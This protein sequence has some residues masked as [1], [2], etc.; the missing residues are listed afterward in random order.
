MAN[1]TPS[2]VVKDL[3]I[4]RN[5]NTFKAKW[6]VP[7]AATQS[8]KDNCFS[9]LDIWVKLYYDVKKG[10]GAKP[11]TWSYWNP[12]MSSVEFDYGD[13]FG[14]RSNLAPNGKTAEAVS[15]A[16]QG[17]HQEGSSYYMGPW[18]SEKL[19]YFKPPKAPKL[20]WDF[21]YVHNQLATLTVK[22]DDDGTEHEEWY[23]TCYCVLMT[24]K[25][26][27]EKVVEKWTT[28]RNA[29]ATWTRSFTTKVNELNA[30][31]T[32]TLTAK[33][34]S[35]GICGNNPEKAKAVSKSIVI[36]P[37]FPSTIKKVALDAKVQGER[38]KVVVQLGENTESI[39]LQRKVGNGSWTDVDQTPVEVADNDNKIVLDDS[40]GSFQAAAGQSVFY[41]VETRSATMPNSPVHSNEFEAKKLYKY[42]EEVYEDPA[43]DVAEC[44]IESVEV[45]KGTAKVKVAWGEGN[46][47]GTE[48]S[49]CNF[50]NGW[51]SNKGPS[52]M[53]I[54]WGSGRKAACFVEDIEEGVTYYFKARTYYDFEGARY[55]SAY[56]DTEEVTWY[57]KPSGINLVAPDH[58]ARGEGIDCYW[59][60]GSDQ[61]QVSYSI[62][63]SDDEVLASGDG[64]SCF[65][66]IKKKKLVGK[67]H[68]TFHVRAGTG[69]LERN[70]NNVTVE[71]VDPPTLSLS[72]P[73]TCTAQPF[74]FTATT[75]DDTA[76]LLCTVISKLAKGDQVV[77]EAVWTGAVEP[78][79][80]ASG[81]DY[82][83]TIEVPEGTAFI[84]GGK[85]AVRVRAVEPL[86]GLTS[87]LQRG[88]F[89]IA[90]SHQA[91]APSQG[92]KLTPVP[93]KRRVHIALAAPEGAA[94]TDVYDIY[95]KSGDGWEL[96]IGGCALD[97]TVRDDY[98][99][100]GKGANLAYRIVLRTKDGDT[101]FW[102]FPYKMDVDTLRFDWGK[103]YLETPYNLEFNRSY[104]KGYEERAHIDGTVN[105]YWDNTVSRSMDAGAATVKGDPAFA[106]AFS[107]LGNHAGPC[108]VR[109]PRG[110]AFACNVD[111]RSATSCTSG[112]VEVSFDISPAGEFDSFSA[113][114]VN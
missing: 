4:E 13:I 70:S 84:D 10:I 108:F 68:V 42:V 6:K 5:G 27:N 106:E 44:T 63:S 58:V 26:G 15:V 101:E 43:E 99:P 76:I 28:T 83:A 65:A 86:M 37:A 95:R 25:N 111:P 96:A 34:Y 82:T 46:R 81:N 61:P 73:Q 17:W 32:I 12:S 78:N 94:Q 92:I 109:T 21:D 47:T 62:I 41:R 49:W 2:W 29:N 66:R 93:D 56:T 90:W 16:V 18:T 50:E 79:W 54:D 24:G 30:G 104:R 113:K 91:V 19:F 88:K 11:V 103:E 77:D 7:S 75:N 102:D 22:S 110:E 60:I 55:Y 114:K 74:S 45:T 23:D 39:K 59:T 72:V 14:S 38:I 52:K 35:R 1:Y 97:D 20:E 98:A 36:G 9:G 105:G 107:L 80:T 71:I 87:G 48:V 100:F 89:D 85:Y 67:D 53:E 51:R 112:A 3:S 64:A 8:K 40:Y 33:A 69:G 31:E 57:S